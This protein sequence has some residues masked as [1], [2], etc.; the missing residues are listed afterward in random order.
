MDSSTEAVIFTDCADLNEFIWHIKEVVECRN[1]M[2]AARLIWQAWGKKIVNEWLGRI[3]YIEENLMEIQDW[4][5]ER[6][7]WGS[8]MVQTWKIQRVTF[9]ETL[10]AANEDFYPRQWSSL[11]QAAH[12]RSNWYVRANLGFQ[13]S[14]NCNGETQC[15]INIIMQS[16]I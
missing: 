5:S 6:S 15:C 13:T 3:A 10:L 14:Y 12:Q 7:P 2:K 4:Q 16:W 9:S 11:S 1:A 8:N